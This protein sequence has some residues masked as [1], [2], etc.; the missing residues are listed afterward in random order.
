MLR[1]AMRFHLIDRVEEWEPARS[2]R[3]RKLTSY[4]E[5]YWEAVDGRPVMPPPF[6]FE[7]LC[8]AGTWLIINTTQRRQRPALLSVDSVRW[9]G[10]VSPGAVLEMVGRIDSLGDESA[11]LSGR[12]TADGQTV[13]E[14][15]SIKCA[16]IDAVDL[17]DPDETERLQTILNRTQG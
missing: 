14:A 15:D 13:L 6:L 10:E 9:F 7:A 2:V 11:V 4:S 1:R 8:Q 12:V 5:D 3:A 17:A 16:L